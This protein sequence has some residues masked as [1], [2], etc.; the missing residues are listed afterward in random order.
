MEHIFL[1]DRT[2]RLDKLLQEKFPEHSRTYFQY[3]IEEGFVLLNGK[4][5]KKK[6]EPKIGDEVRITFFSLPKPS[7]EPEKISLNIIYEDEDIIVINK[8]AGMVVHPACGNWSK[9]LVN[10]L[11]FHC[12]NL[13]DINT[14][15]F[16]PGIVH[17]LDKDTSGLIVAA[18]T[19]K[20][21]EKLI[22]SFKEKRIEKKYLAICVGKPPEGLFSAP[23]CRHPKMR[24]KMTISS[25]GKAAS[26]SFKILA[27]KELLSFLEVTLLTGRTHQIRV[28]L[29]H[30]KTPI[31]G[32]SLYGNEALN[33]KFNVKR[34]LLHA[35]KLSFAHPLSDKILSFIAPLP[36]D[37]LSFFSV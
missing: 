1:V 14:D 7:L 28:H 19:N 15:D 22:L 23:I 36:D 16:R 5:V 13:K 8:P 35:H 11:L 12:E 31:L 24:K 29:S 27:S 2:T 26:S 18:K 21:K 25:S 6:E 37:M 34:Q 33:K 32:D 9:T 3:L 30:L 10:A 20:A 17:R 4:K